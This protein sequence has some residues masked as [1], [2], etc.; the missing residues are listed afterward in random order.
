MQKTFNINPTGECECCSSYDVTLCSNK[1]ITERLLNAIAH[2]YDDDTEQNRY[3]VLCAL[4]DTL[5]S[6]VVATYPV[7]S[8]TIDFIDLISDY[9]I[10]YDLN[11][12]IADIDANF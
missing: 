8:L 12:L 4:T 3:S 11:A 5:N 1:L 6:N 9:I 7:E 2:C 10:E